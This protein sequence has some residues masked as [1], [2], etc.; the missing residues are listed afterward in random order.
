MQEI[1]PLALTKVIPTQLSSD[2]HGSPWKPPLGECGCFLWVVEKLPGRKRTNILGHSC[3]FSS[4]RP[5][6]AATTPLI[7]PETLSSVTTG[8][9]VFLAS[10]KNCFCP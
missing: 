3:I 1:A 9:V 5:V 8:T 2:F 4:G 6:C 10:A 7:L